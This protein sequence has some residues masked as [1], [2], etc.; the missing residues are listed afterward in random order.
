[1][2]YLYLLF[3]TLLLT[4][5]DLHVTC[6]PFVSPS[7]HPAFTT[8]LPLSSPLSIPHPY[9]NLFYTFFSPVIPRSVV[10]SLL[11]SPHP[12][13]LLISL[14]PLFNSLPLTSS[15]PA[16]PFPFS[17]PFT[18]LS[19]PFSLP[20]HSNFPTLSGH[21]PSFHAY[22]SPT[23]SPQRHTRYLVNT[24]PFNAPPHTTPP[25]PSHT[26]SPSP[27]YTSSL[28][29]LP[30]LTHHA[31]TSLFPTAVTVHKSASRRR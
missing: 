2:P 30:S 4:P 15:L 18:L 16:H 14:T 21:S 26:P 25:R 17:R 8:S 5:S 23:H 24:T 13:A 9:K 19:N 3:L 11:A 27:S 28:L 1:M 7:L 29:F 31:V 6:P 22:S 10:I 12:L 20:R